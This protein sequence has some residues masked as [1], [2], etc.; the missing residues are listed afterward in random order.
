VADGS[1]DK[2][3]WYKRI[4][5]REGL[6]HVEKPNAVEEYA[7][8]AKHVFESALAR[9]SPET[10]RA[11][12]RALKSLGKFMDLE[13]PSV[14]NTVQKLISLQRIDADI[15]LQSF[16]ANMEKE[17][18]SPNTISQRIAGI[19][20]YVHQ[21]KRVGW[22]EWEV[23]VEAP[24]IE[25]VKDTRGPTAD[26]FK[27]ILRVTHE[28]TGRTAAR[29]RLMVYMLSFMGLRIDSVLSID[30]E[31]ID[32]RRK[33]VSV[34]WK[35]KKHRVIRPVPKSTMAMIKL[36]LKERGKREGPLFTNF[37]LDEKGDGRLTRRSGHR[38]IQRLGSKA[39]LEGLHP[40]AF[41]HFAATMALEIS[42]GNRHKV[43]K[44]TG[45]ESD[46]TLDIYDDERQDEAREMSQLIE[47]HWLG[48]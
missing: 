6:V 19:R 21:A 48:E 46:K 14:T 44:L 25:K 13:D 41:R 10:I 7:R 36:W 20:F 1:D 4:I 42:D 37:D 23:E 43:R 11:Y 47:D 29:N 3:E 18:L 31:H 24:K 35:G 32:S 2:P 45:H 9:K 15:L 30:L 16:I 5:E 22:V 38:I 40:H 39:G 27:E 34:R 28:L 8:K 12:Q 26:E 33:E 17:G